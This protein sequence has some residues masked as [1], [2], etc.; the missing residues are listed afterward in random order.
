[1]FPA[2]FLYTVVAMTDMSKN[3]ED[4]GKMVFKFIKC[5]NSLDIHYLRELT[6]QKIS[7]L[8]PVFACL[9]LLIPLVSE[10][11]FIGD[12]VTITRLLNGSTPDAT[13]CGPFVVTVE[14]GNNDAIAISPGNNL[15]VNVE[16]S[17]ILIEFGPSGGSGGPSSSD[18]VIVIDDLDW[19]GDPSSV[20]T[21]IT[22]DTDLIGFNSSFISF[23]DHRVEVQ[24]AGL[25]WSG[26]QHLDMY[27]TTSAVPIPAAAWLFGSG[28]IGLI[29][30]A[31]RKKS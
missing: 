14:A 18:H 15:F 31:R 3:E 8:M 12:D 2:I 1:M 24:I 9:L 4:E 7:S 30:V 11:S 23:F 26:G 21:G 20:L 13:C 22:F 25:G 5:C 29:G 10:A 28:L 17:S 6:T 19:V 27:L 16:E